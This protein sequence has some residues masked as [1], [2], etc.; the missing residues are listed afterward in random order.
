[1]A[2]SYGGQLLENYCTPAGVASMKELL[3]TRPWDK[4]WEDRVRHLFLVN[5]HTLAEKQITWLRAQL[6]FQYQY[7]QAIWLYTHWLYLPKAASVD[8]ASDG[9][10]RAFYAQR[11][12]LKTNM[13]A[14]VGRLVGELD[15]ELHSIL[16]QTEPALWLPPSKSCSWCPTAPGP[17][18]SFI[19]QVAV[20]D[21]EEPIRV[22][23]S[24]DP[25]R[26]VESLFPGQQAILKSHHG[27]CWLV[28]PPFDEDLATIATHVRT[29]KKGTP[30]P[31]RMFQKP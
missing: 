9:Y 15:P 27:R 25:G 16:L 21:Q 19:D 22:F 5:P 7:R 14:K 8:P 13:R 24:S 11:E 3:A 23:W 28:P 26:F 30:G 6:K 18:N 29:S 17:G 12:E 10:W 2:K 20:L 1:V 4:M 31:E